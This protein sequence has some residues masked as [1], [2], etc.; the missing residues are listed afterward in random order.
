MSLRDVA[1]EYRTDVPV[2]AV[3]GVSLDIAPGEIVGIAGE[4]GCGKST[5][6]YAMTRLLRAPGEIT[7]GSV[8]FHAT[9]SDD[10]IDVLG[11][12]GEKLRAFHWAR[13]AMVFQSAMSALNPVVTIERQLADVFPAHGVQLSRRQTHERCAELVELVGIDRSRLSAFP[14]ELSGGMRQRVMIAMALALQPDVIVMD[15]PTTALDVVVQREIL[16]EIDRLRSLFGFAVVFITHDLS[17]LLE[18]SDHIAIMYAGRIVEYGEAETILRAPR[19]PYTV[20]A[21]RLVPEPARGPPRAP[22]NSR[23]TAGPVP[24]GPRVCFSTAVPPG[25]RPVPHGRPRAPHPRSRR[26][27]RGR[28][29]PGP[30]GLAGIVAVIGRLSPARH[31]APAPGA[32]GGSARARASECGRARYR[33]PG[34]AD[35]RADRGRAARG[36]AGR[37]EGG[38]V[39]TLQVESIRK[40]FTVRGQQKLL[41]VD[42]VSFTLR[43]GTTVALVGESGSG[44]STVARILA[45]LTKPTSGR[46][47][48]DGAEIAAGRRATVRYR[49]AVQMVFQDPFGSL[50]PS[51]TIG[52]HLRRP[53]QLHH[54]VPAGSTVDA[55]VAELLTRVNLG[56]PTWWR[57]GTRTSCPAASGSASPSPARWPRGRRCCWPTSRCRCSTCPI[58]LEILE[59][60]DRARIENDLAVLYITHDLAT[61]RY[62]A[63]TIMVM[64]RGEVVESGPADDVI[65]RPAHPYT[66]L[67]ARSAPDPEGRYG[68][69]DLEAADGPLPDPADGGGSGAGT[70]PVRRPP[71]AIAADGSDPGCRFR[72]RCPFVMEICAERRPPV[73]ETTPGHHARCWLL[74]PSRAGGAG[75]SGRVAA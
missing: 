39:S 53:L 46:V 60:L 45:R 9:G 75:R 56:R 26:A 73:I 28:H 13:V 36:R 18:I 41:A 70:A 11:L 55:G 17:L 40:V 6:A 43:S 23:L 68:A 12:T 57:P 10:E 48:L 50:N 51:H 44:K 37:R 35:S 66:Q 33:T 15:E 24:A 47:T 4:S 21:H 54:L 30:D 52:Y 1:V 8:T 74:D 63:T 58:R 31:P 7:S 27:G 71:T 65:V 14:H 5:L 69:P 38:A 72:D 67:L 59:L 29:E 32:A 34:R 22:R 62:F 3:R 20:G 19:H 64:Y 42:D 16:S 25:I 2:L 61:A 49:N